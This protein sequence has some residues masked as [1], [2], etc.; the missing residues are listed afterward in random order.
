MSNG[1]NETRMYQETKTWNPF[2]GCFYACIYCKYSFQ[3]Q[4]KRLGKRCLDCYHYRPHMHPE[5]LSKIPNSKNIFVVGDGDITFSPV[6]Y[7]LEIILSAR[8]HSIDHPN[9]T[10]YFQSKNPKY[11]KLFLNMFP[12]N[13]VLLTTLETNRD[14]GYKKISEAPKPSERFRDFLELNYPRKG[15]TIEPVM[16]F[17]VEIFAS[18]IRAINPEFVYFG[19]NSRPNRVNLPEP[20]P[21]KVRSFISRISPITQIRFKELR[22]ME[23]D[24]K[25]LIGDDGE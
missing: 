20:S 21:E 17:D 6:S 15:V 18:W 4:L 2:V 1:L 14:K 11:F 10:Y 3:A 8:W 13:T 19:F 5:R 9:T 12:P 7:T 25:R 22:S 23:K 24:E 16:D